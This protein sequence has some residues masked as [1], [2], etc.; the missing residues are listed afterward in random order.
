MPMRITY[1]ERYERGI[2][3][4]VKTPFFAAELHSVRALPADLGER[5]E[6]DQSL[7]GAHLRPCP[8]ARNRATMYMWS[9]QQM[10]DLEDFAQEQ[11]PPLHLEEQAVRL[12]VS[13]SESPAKYTSWAI[14]EM[15]LLVEEANES[16]RTTPEPAPA[17][18]APPETRDVWTQSA[19][20]Q[21]APELRH[22]SCQTVPAV[23]SRHQW[24]QTPAP[25]KCRESGTQA[26]V[27]TA[28][29]STTA[30][31]HVAQGFSPLLPPPVASTATQTA[32]KAAS[33]A[34]KSA[35]QPA[36][37]Q[38][39][40]RTQDHR[41]PWHFVVL[42]GGRGAGA[43][44]EEVDAALRSAGHKPTRCWRVCSRATGR[45][46]GLY[47]VAFATVQE[48]TRLLEAGLTI[49][50]A[51]CAAE[52]AHTRQQ[53]PRAWGHVELQPIPRGARDASPASS[54]P[55][56]VFAL[57]RQHSAPLGP[58][59][60]T[61]RMAALAAKKVKE[62]KEA[63]EAMEGSEA[64]GDSFSAQELVRSVKADHN[65]V[66]ERMR[67]LLEEG[68]W[69]DVQFS[70]GKEES[71]FRAH[72]LVLAS[73]GPA[74][75]ALMYGPLA[76]PGTVRVPDVS[77]G[78]FRAL[79]HYLYTDELSP[80]GVEDAMRAMRVASK[81][82]LPQMASRCAK[83]LADMLG[84]GNVCSVLEFARDSGDQQL[85]ERCL[86]FLCHHAEA[87]L[88]HPSFLAASRAT[89]HQVLDQDRLVVASEADV[90]EAAVR[91]SAEECRRRGLPSRP[92]NR[93]EVLREFL[94][95]LRLLTLSAEEFVGV[96]G[97]KDV[98]TPEEYRDVLSHL[99]RPSSCELPPAVCCSDGHRGAGARRSEGVP[100]RCAHCSG[101]LL[102]TY[103]GNFCVGCKKA[104]D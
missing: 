95:K 3:T 61:P 69:S 72:R 15:M 27:V 48:A 70:V 100:S 19:P 30:A 53:L 84:T 76:E 9:A 33:A 28:Q 51:H 98:L 35:R 50:G 37:E 66:L 31:L 59:P 88:R 16:G 21:P 90:A 41:A 24:S 75:A 34:G 7:C 101:E 83:Y 13:C 40:Q 32:P 104:A 73:A 67:R 45:L 1:N 78:A 58:G 71:G 39:S 91:W 2:A 82:R 6:A 8:E 77:P 62:A 47:R 4:E 42:R 96:P 57:A 99:V 86:Q 89:L 94:G 49:R 46:T 102:T 60:E 52:P 11:Q 65:G 63:M 68:A 55:P 93:R 64:G 25:A 29:K 103:M 38:P 54:R 79:L 80:A 92:A 36:Q 26:A 12:R 14:Y 74:L 87:V 5:I 97:L 43:P 56:A 20:P 18:P 85:A 23:R 22:S 17:A 81:Y 10:W 44:A